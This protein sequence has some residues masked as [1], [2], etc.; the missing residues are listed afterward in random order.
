VT[1]PDE[2]RASHA[3]FTPGAFAAA[4]G[5]FVLI[6]TID[7]AVPGDR[8]PTTWALTGSM[9]GGAL[10]SGAVALLVS[11]AGIRVV[12]VVLVAFAASSCLFLLSV[13]RRSER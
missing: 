12:P 13:P 3:S 11:V 10:G 2:V 6:G 4:L 1:S 8:R 9:I 7:A 5:A